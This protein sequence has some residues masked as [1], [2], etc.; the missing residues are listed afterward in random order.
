MIGVTDKDHTQHHR[1]DVTHY[2]DYNYKA[3]PETR[4]EAGTSIWGNKSLTYTVGSGDDEIYPDQ[5]YKNS[6]PDYFDHWLK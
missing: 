5:A 2:S 6:N 4:K 1:D 3:P